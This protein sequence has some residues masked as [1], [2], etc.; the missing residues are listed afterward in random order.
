MRRVL[1]SLIVVMLSACA[2]NYEKFY[3]PFMLTSSVSILPPERPPTIVALGDDVSMTV[4]QLYRQGYAPVGQ[5]NFVG[6]GA[7]PGQ[8]IKQAQRVGA[9]VVAATSKYQNTVSGALPLTLPMSTTSYTSG[10]ATVYG[11]SGYATG[12]YS[13]TTTTNGTQTTYIPYS[14]DRYEQHALFFGRL[15]RQGAGVMILPLTDEERREAGTNQALKVV[16]IRDESPAYNADV[17][18][19]DMIVSIDGAPPG[20]IPVVVSLLGAPGPDVRL[21][22]IRGAE[23]LE[24]TLGRPA[25]W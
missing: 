4:R 18:P 17:L 6:P 1:I 19:G 3:Q 7:N 23:K 24:K 5:S 8:L 10:T 16:A 25:N 13:G 22:I 9:E 2:N 12:N 20:S 14:V 15:S 21:T 11:S